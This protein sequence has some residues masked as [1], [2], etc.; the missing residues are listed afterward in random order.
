M[1][2]AEMEQMDTAR[3][4]HNL[5]MPKSLSSLSGTSCCSLMSLL[6]THF[7]ASQ[8]C[9][10][11]WK[12]CTCKTRPAWILTVWVKA[13]LGSTVLA[14]NPSKLSAQELH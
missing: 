1:G 9:L 11:P 2:E 6:F 7:P 3:Y 4:N 14:I 12:C 13:V 8:Q 10:C 5:L